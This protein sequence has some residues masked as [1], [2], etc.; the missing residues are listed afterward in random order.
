MITTK[1][2]KKHTVTTFA[3]ITAKSALN[4]PYTAHID[5][6]AVSTIR[7]THEKSL[8]DRVLHDRTNCGNQHAVV[9]TPATNPITVMPRA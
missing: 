9:N 1:N 8:V 4:T 7:Y 2:N 3:A 6:P 5:T